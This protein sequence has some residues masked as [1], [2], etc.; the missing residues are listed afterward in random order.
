MLSEFIKKSLTFQAIPRKSTL[1]Q[2]LL[3]PPSCG[4]ADRHRTSNLHHRCAPA[5]SLG[6]SL[7]SSRNQST[8]SRCVP[9]TLECS[10][11]TWWSCLL[12]LFAAPISLP[13]TS[14]ILGLAQWLLKRSTQFS[15]YTT[16]PCS[17]KFESFWTPSHVSNPGLKPYHHASL[18]HPHE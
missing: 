18:L 11:R 1:R 9:S 2:P 3:F 4:L 10:Y 6:S 17:Y 15:H 8:W 16:S 12:W 7:A 13:S 14:S 5:S